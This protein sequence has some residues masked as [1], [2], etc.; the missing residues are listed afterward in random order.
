MS[1]A[2]ALTKRYRSHASTSANPMPGRAISTR[3]ADRSVDRTQISLP[4][5]LLSTTN[6]L[7]YDAPDIHSLHSSSA[8]STGSFGDS[9][10]SRG[11]F[12]S[13]SSISSPDVSRESSPVEP[14]HLSMYFPP[15]KLGR[16]SAGSQASI[17]G[18]VDVPAVPTRALS[19]TKQSHQAIATKRSQSQVRHAPP[20]LPSPV[21]TVRSSIDLFGGP[22]DS[23]HPFG[24]ELAQVSELAE[25]FGAREATVWD[26]EEQ[27]LIEHGLQKWG[28]QDYLDEIAALFGGVFDDT[29]FPMG[30]GWI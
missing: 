22:T 19:H 29:P 9:D 7:A 8:S 28:V 5:E 16:A 1:L 27:Y 25:E 14:N 24:A 4:I 3:K 23:N 18:D 17:S 12:S 20:S 11:V 21:V 13:S 2:R 26:A 10:S 30:E 6:V 15:S